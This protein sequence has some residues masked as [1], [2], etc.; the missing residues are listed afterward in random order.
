MPSQDHIIPSRKAH[1]ATD[2]GVG[3]YPCGY[4]GCARLGLSSQLLAAPILR[5]VRR[6]RQ[7]RLMV[8]F[9]GDS[10]TCNGGWGFRAGLTEPLPGHERC[11]LELAAT[12]PV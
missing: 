8:V 3:R 9:Q 12:E 4:V 2:W 6:T 7:A 1:R 11:V 10:L 5:P